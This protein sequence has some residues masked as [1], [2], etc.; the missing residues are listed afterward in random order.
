MVKQESRVLWYIV[1]NDSASHTTV[2]IHCSR[3]IDDLKKAIN[4]QRK[5]IAV[6]EMTL[7][8]VH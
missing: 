1:L 4:T 6:S 8:K 7:W 5:D 3:S 2:D